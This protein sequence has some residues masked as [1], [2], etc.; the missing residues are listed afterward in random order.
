MQYLFGSRQTDYG[1]RRIQDGSYARWSEL[2]DRIYFEFCESE[3]HPPESDQ[4]R[5]R[6]VNWALEVMSSCP[7]YNQVKNQIF[8]IDGLRY[9]EGSFLSQ[10]DSHAA[11]FGLVKNI[12]TRSDWEDLNFG[13]QQA[14]LRDPLGMTERPVI[15]RGLLDHEVGVDFADYLS[16]YL[17]GLGDRSVLS[18][19]TWSEGEQGISLS[20]LTGLNR[21]AGQITGLS[22][23]EVRFGDAAQDLVGFAYD[24][25][26][27]NVL[28]LINLGKQVRSLGFRGKFAHYTNL[29]EY[30]SQGSLIR[31]VELSQ[32]PRT[33]SLLPGSVI[34]F[35]DF[36]NRPEE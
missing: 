25:R 13:K 6:F 23:R 11:D 29:Y 34:V 27:G 24:G 20:I 31:H 15:Y 30:N 33:I 18:L 17:V 10:A 2:Y 26:Q 9:T 4:E 5:K 12:A 19:P 1:Q 8:F 16:Q 22:P 35:D 3:A 28:C 21:I 32:T 36:S 14:L 7:E